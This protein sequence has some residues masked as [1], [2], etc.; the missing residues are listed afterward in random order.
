[1]VDD[2]AE[3]SAIGNM[4]SKLQF[5]NVHTNY[6]LMSIPHS[7]QGHTNWQYGSGQHASRPRK[8]L[9]SA[10]VKL[11]S[12]TGCPISIKHLII[13]ASRQW[14]TGRNVT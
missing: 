4:E 9:G 5:N 11:R 13:E 10:N 2:G 8:I 7:I 12:D 3:Y 6:S 1:M 14:V